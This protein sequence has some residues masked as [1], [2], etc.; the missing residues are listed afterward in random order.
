MSHSRSPASILYLHTSYS[1]HVDIFTR[2]LILLI[3]IIPHYY[4][5][6][7]PLINNLQKANK[8]FH[9]PALSRINLMNSIDKDATIWTSETSRVELE[10]WSRTF[11][12]STRRFWINF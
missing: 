7:I 4:R 5:L 8:H 12:R 11:A 6:Y 1:R 9:R 2:S 10:Q 3:S